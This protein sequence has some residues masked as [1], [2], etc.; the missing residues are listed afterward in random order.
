MK[1]N[2]QTI[3]LRVD[4]SSKSL[5]KRALAQLLLKIVYFHGSPPTKAQVSS[6]LAAILGT[7]INT[8]KIDDAFELLTT[9]GKI[10]EK[11]GKY[12]IAA[13]KKEKIDIAV[14]EFNNKQ[15]RILENYFL[16]ISTDSNF[17]AQWFEDVTIEFF[18]EYS[19]EWVS[20]LCLTTTTAVKNKH[21]GIQ[22]I[23]DLV[24]DNN[25]NILDKDKQWLKAQYLK[26]LQS[27]DNDVSSILW[28]Y[29]TSRFS[30]SLIVS[31]TSADPITIDEFSNS[32]CIL[33]TN[34]LM[35]LDLEKSKF[36]DAFNSMELIF[37]NLKISPIYFFSTRDEFSS[38]MDWKKK[39]T[40]KVVENFSSEVIA[41]AIDPFLQTALHRGCVTEDDFNEFFNQMMDIPQY[42]SDLL[43]IRMHDN[44]E[45]D[46]AIEKGQENEVLKRSINSVYRSKR[47]K[48]KKK[49]SL[50]HDAGLISGAEFI[51]A[52]E[53]CFIL[54]RDSSLNE[55]ALDIQV[56]NEIP[57][58]IGL[59][60]LINLLAIDNGGTDIDP[61][62]CAPLFA[63]IIKLALIP[64]RDIFRLE[65]LSR[66]LD[67]E[68][69]IANLPSEQVIDIAKELHYNNI[70]G[71]S[72]E[73]SSLQLNRRFQSA[74]IEFQT[75]LHK[76]KQET[77][78]EKEEKEKYIQISDKATQRLRAEYTGKLTDEYDKKIFWNR[79]LAFIVAPIVTIL[80][81]G[82]IIYLMKGKDHES[83]WI[84]EGLG[85]LVNIIS[86]F[87]LDFFF[88]KKRLRRIH[89]ERINGIS[90]KVEQKI[91][92]DVHD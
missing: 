26:F 83:F 80:I 6:E 64:E 48:N 82:A 41:D 72:E 32:K 90:D 28:D 92:N 87:I 36:N 35:Y 29:G 85:V 78:F 86:W 68:T 43:E 20:D 45:V 66:M 71:V 14:N 61:T 58:A 75:D 47:G 84:T 19:S 60:T 22:A 15:T 4:S 8:S 88:I 77:H 67:V 21:R 73:D 27:N 54:S 13:D 63:S 34:I 18:N 23:L 65:D 1:K 46:A 55:S 53:K 10:I 17:V 3:Y 49:H 57:I 7:S 38:A 30:S 91:K 37:I 59:D 50:E 74:K 33:D 31:N 62:N 69:Q 40:I 42:F 70:T 2:L 25:K 39:E 24:T 76:Q 11:Q 81:V 44:K 5:T 52:T 51:R 9:D 12:T 89:S 79:I 16:P 56:K